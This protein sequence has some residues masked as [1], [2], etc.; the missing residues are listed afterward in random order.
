MYCQNCKKANM[1]GECEK[2]GSY[3]T[4]SQLRDENFSCFE[5]RIYKINKSN[6]IFSPDENI[7]TEEMNDSEIYDAIAYCNRIKKIISERNERDLK[8]EV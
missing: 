1:F 3:K 7:Y 4:D 6:R 8:E 5:G 2:F